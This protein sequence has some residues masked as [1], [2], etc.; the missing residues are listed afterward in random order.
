[1]P[2]RFGLPVVAVVAGLAALAA[3]GTVLDAALRPTSQTFGRTLLAGSDSDEVLLTYDDGPNDPA[4]ARL[5][6]ILDRYGARAAFFC[7]GRFAREHPEIVRA[8]H[9]AGHTVGNHT[10]THPWLTTQSALRIREELRACNETL[11]DTLGEPVRFFRPPH[12]AR[13]PA[14]FR[15]AAELGLTV[16][17]WNVMGYDWKPI[18][19]ESIL[20]HI[21]RG[22]R[23]AARSGRGANILLHEGWDVRFGADRSA[24]LAATATLLARF[25][26]EGRRI[27]TLDEVNQTAASR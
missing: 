4:T 23:R 10:E 14:V 24:T 17:Q 22:L 19:A 21:D 9:A 27:V 11:E 26:T 12:G 8:I 2:S 16:V 20:R 7:I 15:A 5:L 6:E 18:G 13:R 1:M 3:A 25:R